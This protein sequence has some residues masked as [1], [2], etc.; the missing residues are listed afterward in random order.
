MAL[1][2]EQKAAIVARKRAGNLT[3]EDK[4]LLVRLKRGEDVAPDEDTS[5]DPT[6]GEMI[7]TV[8]RSALEGHTAGISE[9]VI[10]GAIA[11][12]QAA[13]AAYPFSGG[14][15]SAEALQAIG[16]QSPALIQADIDRR[17]ALKEKMPALDLGA[18]VTGALAP[19]PLNV[20]GHIFKGVR[21]AGGLNPALKGAVPEGASKMQR[22]GIFANKVAAS[23]VEGMVGGAGFE[24]TRKAAL[25]PSGFLQPEESPG[26]E[27]SAEMGAAVGAGLTVLGAGFRGAGRLMA[28]AARKAFSLI[29]GVNENAVT[30]A[31]NFPE[32]L[33]RAKSIDDVKQIV[34]DFVGEIRTKYLDKE[35]SIKEAEAAV[36]RVKQDIR[37][38]LG[39]N[40]AE[41]RA[42][43]RDAERV[44]D[45]AFDKKV[46]EIKSVPNPI[47]LTD[48]V[49][50]AMF[51]LK[52]KV[53]KGSNHAKD[54]LRDSKEMLDLTQ[55]PHVIIDK[56]NNLS[57]AG[58]PA[59][60][61]PSE[62]AMARLERLNER[63]KAM[64][65]KIPLP[66]AKKFL[67]QIDDDINYVEALPEFQ[68]Q[69]TQGLRAVRDF[70][71]AKLK[72]VSPEYAKRML[73]VAKNTE[74]LERAGYKFRNRE[75]ILSTL[76]TIDR[77][78]REES[79]KMLMDLGK[80]TGHDFK[81]P[82]EKF[83]ASKRTLENPEAIQASLPEM[84]TVGAARGEVA[85]FTPRYMEE[86]KAAMLGNTE[87][88][89]ILNK[90]MSELEEA[91]AAYW[92]L[93]SITPGDTESKIRSL[94]R[95]DI[96][97][98][99][100]RGLEVRKVFEQMS[101]M[102]GP[103]F[104]QLVDD[105]RLNSAFDREAMRGSREVNFWAILGGA[106]A[107]TGYGYSQ[108]KTGMGAAIGA[109]VGLYLGKYGP[110]AARSLLLASAKLRGLPTPEKIAH[111]S[112][113]D[114]MKKDL[115]RDLTEYLV[116][117]NSKLGAPVTIP[118]E[119]RADVRLD[120][121]NSKALSNIEKAKNLNALND[122][123]TILSAEK[124]MTGKPLEA[125][126]GQAA[127]YGPQEMYGPPEPESDLPTEVVQAPQQSPEEAPPATSKEDFRARNAQAISRMAKQAYAPPKT[128]P[129]KTRREM[130]IEA[131]KR[132]VVQE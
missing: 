98:P 26:I 50:D 92:P 87:Q 108:E 8:S 64:P 124:I 63:V 47:A 112:L 18:Q 39:E 27:R 14:E 25:E 105:L 103:D 97:D 68:D 37:L 9:P 16:E 45:R 88:P 73:P 102:G 19:S 118:A 51:D 62:A 48:D 40:K 15:P 76:A 113:P 41:A 93:R 42:Q 71:D 60:G 123:G 84:Q 35:I 22:A 101:Q 2:H 110:A 117:S 54:A 96:T 106:V 94:M 61:T 21:E 24:A 12:Q 58:G 129:S 28:P 111:W 4:I 79:L 115:T 17:R 33:Q 104:M 53:I 3:R 65:D 36:N 80:A 13:P 77:S 34:D 7:E 69:M 38:T 49:H 122:N 120:I 91:K 10:S 75:R 130:A 121:E 55:V 132:R 82:F 23:S 52:E 46:A 127:L 107:G 5:N 99:N 67:Q 43:L 89:Y 86:Q 90:R 126:Q 59:V 72:T 128:Y 116:L 85:K 1:T 30:E 20:G 131:A 109:G 83:I 78:T 44:A 57:I 114:Q 81:T 100:G 66:E 74:L 6:L 95:S 32:K 56:I 70:V 119:Q 11:A 29:F 31:Y 125:L